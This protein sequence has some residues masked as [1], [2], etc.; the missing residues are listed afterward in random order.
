MAWVKKDKATRPV[1]I[2]SRGCNPHATEAA[3]V[4]GH[5]GH[6]KGAAYVGD[7]RSLLP[8]AAWDARLRSRAAPCTHS[9]RGAPQ[10][11]HALTPAPAAARA[12][13]PPSLTWRP[14]TPR[15]RGW[16]STTRPWPRSR[17]SGSRSST[18]AATGTW[19]TCASTARW[20][21]SRSTSCRP[22]ARGVAL[23]P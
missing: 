13:P 23:L 16:S 11:Q 3:C 1:T 6:G 21:A 17:R 7:G 18:A 15:R 9:S 5:E 4:R 8:P 22:C 20:T 19:R 2:S 12:A 14:A 10:P